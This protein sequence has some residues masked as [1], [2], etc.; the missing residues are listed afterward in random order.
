MVL[1]LEK[2]AVQDDFVKAYNIG[3]DGGK[4]PSADENVV[5]GHLL[6]DKVRSHN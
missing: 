3:L 6:G 5:K 4:R 1:T 2:I